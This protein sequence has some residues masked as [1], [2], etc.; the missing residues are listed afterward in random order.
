MCST[1]R[2]RRCEWVGAELL[3]R[4]VPNPLPSP[5]FRRPLHSGLVQRRKGQLQA[6]LA[7]FQRLMQLYPHNVDTAKQVARSL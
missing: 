3:H 4:F 6:S 7:T 5:F 1:V 2:R